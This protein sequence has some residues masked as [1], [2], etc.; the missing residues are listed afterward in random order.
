MESLRV[1][2]G[3]VLPLFL[4]MA[5]GYGLRRLRLVNDPVLKGINR[6]VFQVFLPLLLFRNVLHTS[7]GEV[8]NPKLLLWAAGGILLV[9]AAAMLLVPLFEKDNRRR[10]A[11]I[12]GIFRSNFVLFGLPVTTA[13]VG[14]GAAGVPSLMAAVAIPLYNVLAV[15]ILEFY[16]GGRPDVRNMLK[17]IVRNPL[18]LATALGL[19]ALLAGISLPP[20]LDKTLDNLAGV[21]TPLALVGLGGTFTFRSVRGSLRP[22]TAGLLGRLL[23]VPALTL[24]ISI[25]LG[26]REVE[27]VSLMALFASPAAVSSFVMAGQMDSDDELAGQLVVIGSLLSVL[28]VFGWT[29]LLVS[30]GFVTP[31]V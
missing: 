16:R 28:T 21:A 19:L 15:V 27:L 23:L 1:A 11:L 12:Q 31:A 25:A 17:G 29:A 20:V 2:A 6:L 26:F 7:I 18:I 3:V 22:L 4:C 10:G 5:L 24:G 14:D 8:W 13:L 9:F 30:G